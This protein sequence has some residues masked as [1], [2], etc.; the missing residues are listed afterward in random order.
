M[1]TGLQSDNRGE[2]RWHESVKNA[3]MHTTARYPNTETPHDGADI[4]RFPYNRLL[5]DGAVVMPPDT[6]KTHRTHLDSRL[7]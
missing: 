2:Q 3:A 6:M 5:V 4:G 1:N 7:D